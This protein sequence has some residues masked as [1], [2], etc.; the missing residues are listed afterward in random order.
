[1]M[2][3]NQ[4]Y[5]KIH[6]RQYVLTCII[7]VVFHSTFLLNCFLKITGTSVIQANTTNSNIEV[8]ENASFELVMVLRVLPA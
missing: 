5:S 8:H 3:I 2:Q 1:M 6:K 4:K 7:R